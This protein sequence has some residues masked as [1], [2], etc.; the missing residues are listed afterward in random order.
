MITRKNKIDYDEIWSYKIGNA[1]EESL[2]DIWHVKRMNNARKWRIKHMVIEGVPC[3][4][5]YLPRKTKRDTSEV[6]L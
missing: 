3:K 4:F 5:C 6:D 1:N 2:Y